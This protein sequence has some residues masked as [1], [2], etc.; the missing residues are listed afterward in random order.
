MSGNGK[1]LDGAL[2]CITQIELD[3]LQV[4]ATGFYFRK[5]EHIVEQGEQRI[6]GL[7]NH[8][9]AV[10]LLRCQFCLQRELRHS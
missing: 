3:L 10:S 8:L 5:V 1:E 2:D 9:Q 6:T 7:L 4:H